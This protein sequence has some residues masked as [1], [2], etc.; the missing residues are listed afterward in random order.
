MPF[1][2]TGASAKRTEELKAEAGSGAPIDCGL[3]QVLVKK[4][5]PV[6]AQLR[7]VRAFERRNRAVAE[8]P[9]AFG[10]LAIA[11]KTSRTHGVALRRCERVVAAT[12]HTPDQE[13][14]PEESSH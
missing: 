1:R 5:R 13:N 4:R 9:S 3:A 11:S 12:R 7:R 6:L 8:S 10:G 14:Q 2:H